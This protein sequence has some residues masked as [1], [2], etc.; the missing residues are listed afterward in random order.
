MEACAKL[1]PNGEKFSVWQLT[2]ETIVRNGLLMTGRPSPAE[3]GQVTSGALHS[4]VFFLCLRILCIFVGVN[5]VIC[6]GKWY[7]SVL[8]S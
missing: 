1:L 8:L 6:F 5:P 7:L 2:A 4:G 3:I